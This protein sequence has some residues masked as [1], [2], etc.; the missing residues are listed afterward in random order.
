MRVRHHRKS[1][2]QVH[3]DDARTK[4]LKNGQ[5][6]IERRKLVGMKSLNHRSAR[7]ADAETAHAT[8]KRPRV[9]GDSDLGRRPILGIEAGDAPSSSALS[10][11]VRT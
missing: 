1:R 9:V 4:L 10:S 2:R 11:T 8:T 3:F 5:C 6:R 7:N